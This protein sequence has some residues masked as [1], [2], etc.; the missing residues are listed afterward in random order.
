MKHFCEF[1]DDLVA[2]CKQYYRPSNSSIIDHYPYIPY[3]PQNWNKILL[4]AESQQLKGNSKGNKSF[5]MRLEEV[6]DFDRI[7]RLGNEKVTK[8]PDVI[9][10]TP[11]DNEYL[12]LALLASYKNIELKNVGLSNA[13]PW[14]LDNRNKK[15]VNELS[16]KSAAFWG[17]ILKIIKPDKIICSGNIANNVIRQVAADSLPTNL[18]VIKIRSASSLHWLGKR[19]SSYSI[20]EETTKIFNRSS[21]ATDRSEKSKERYLYF[22]QIAKEAIQKAN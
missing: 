7:C 16:K 11:W 18:Q 1:N 9:G 20:D 5:K 14:H 13:I 21:I 6:T 4:L 22:M 2:V 15:M 17:D 10:I 3:I 19:V 12:K 8:S